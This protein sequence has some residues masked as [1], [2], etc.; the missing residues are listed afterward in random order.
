MNNS[1]EATEPSFPPATSP[2]R[3]AL[4]VSVFLIIILTAAVDSPVINHSFSNWDD[5]KHVRI[6]WKPGWDRAWRIVSDFRL[7]HTDVRYYSPVHFL[8]LMADQVLVGAR[9]RPEAWIS[10]LNNVLFHI[11]NTLLLFALLFMAGIGRR[12][13]MVGAL[14]FAIHPL[15]VG[16]VAWIVERKNVLA[17]L[18]YLSGFL[19]FVKYLRTERAAYVPITITL[20]VA[21]LLSKP[22]VVTLPVACLAWL[23]I[24][25]D[26]K[27]AGRGPALLVVL[28]FLVAAGFGAFVVSTEISYPGILPPPP[29]RPLLAAGSIWFYLGKF[30]FPHELV[31]IYPRWDVIRHVWVFLLG[32][33]AFAVVIAAVIRY[34]RSIDPLTLWGGIFFLINIL[35]ISGLVPFGHMG[36]SYVADHFM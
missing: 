35:P 7:Q 10:K 31:V 16:T 1:F 22:S 25:P 15:Q 2:S 24:V 4:W 5:P 3:L 6:I 11:A 28:L 27:P 18:F 36:H 30:V 21:G 29:Y 26:R 13:A 19:M 20:F 34:R 32:F 9:D 12:A 14:V 33:A 23:L 17:V 8:S